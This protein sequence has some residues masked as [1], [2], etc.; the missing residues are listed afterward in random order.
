MLHQGSKL[1]G[2][3]RIII[4]EHKHVRISGWDT[5]QTPLHKPNQGP[6][7]SFIRGAF[8]ELQNHH[9]SDTMKYR[10]NRKALLLY[11]DKKKKGR[12]RDQSEQRILKD[13]ISLACLIS[14]NPFHFS[15]IVHL[16]VVSV[17][18][19]LLL[20]AP[21]HRWVTSR[22]A[23]SSPSRP[24]LFI[25]KAS[26]FAFIFN[27]RDKSMLYLIQPVCGSPA[28]SALVQSSAERKPWSFLILSYGVHLVGG[29]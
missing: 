11:S 12:K 6:V 7:Q 27:H 16:H 28:L 19:H 24:E 10:E 17:K 29:Q 25:Y 2:R 22:D 20:H 21:K 15:W 14:D 8:L 13:S 3:T 1:G 26:I 23:R 5:L 9:T 4:L 18:I